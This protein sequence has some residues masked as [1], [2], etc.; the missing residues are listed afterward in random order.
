MTGPTPVTAQTDAR[1]WV[2][3]GDV[4]GRADL[5]ALMLDAVER[6]LPDPRLVLLGDLI[7]RGPD[8]RGAV[9]LAR[10]VPERFPGS[11]VL[12]GNHEA[13]MLAAIDGNRAERDD[14]LTWGG[15]PTCRA[16]GVDARVDRDRLAAA[17]APH[18]GDIAFLRARPRRLDGFGAA[19]GFVFVHAG[20]DPTAPLDHQS[21]RDLIWMREPFLSW[22]HA[23]ERRVVHGHTISARPE[24][25]PH[26]IGVDTGAYGS[27]LLS[28]VV[29]EVGESPRFIGAMVGSGVQALEP[30]RG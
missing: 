15:E 10:E 30:D 1:P 4:H 28:A 21:A 20:V 18:A 19:E 29:L 16:Y 7:D 6:D 13:W 26:R 22:P 14:W 8:V 12:M 9:R 11:H 25:R 27:G 24:T 5:L 3:I 23:L 2:A 17:F